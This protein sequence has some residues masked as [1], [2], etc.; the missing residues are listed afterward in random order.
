[1]R[2]WNN[3]TLMM[4]MM[5]TKKISLQKINYNLPSNIWRFEFYVCVFIQKTCSIKILYAPMTVF[6]LIYFSL[7][8][9][10]VI[11]LKRLFCLTVLNIIKN[12]LDFS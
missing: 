10:V 3:G 6:Y 7:M 8:T 4:L 1:M 9:L 12:G 5:T 2:T 11:N